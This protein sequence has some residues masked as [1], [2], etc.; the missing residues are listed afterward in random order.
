MT[1]DSQN[2]GSVRGL[3]PDTLIANALTA[4][5]P[6][7]TAGSENPKP[8]L[9]TSPENFSFSSQ[10]S[11]ET[12][13]AN[14]A[15]GAPDHCQ[16][17]WEPET[18]DG[19]GD[20]LCFAHD[21]NT[22]SSSLASQFSEFSPELDTADSTAF[23]DP[24]A[25]LSAGISPCTCITSLQECSAQL[26]SL[27]LSPVS[28]QTLTTM[29][30]AAHTLYQAIQCTVCRQCSSTDM[31]N[32]GLTR[33]VFRFLLHCWS[34]VARA[35]SHFLL[36]PAASTLY[37]TS[38]PMD[39]ALREK[40]W[41]KW[42]RHLFREGLIGSR[43][44]CLAEPLSPCMNLLSLVDALEFQQCYFDTVG[45][46]YL[47]SISSPSSSGSDNGFSSR[48]VSERRELSHLISKEVREFVAK[49]QFSNQETTG[50]RV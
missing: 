22:S 32:L 47:D 28:V 7:R 23:F 44:S 40:H 31:Q 2:Y 5:Q 17:Q 41:K 14:A 10:A 20:M 43:M 29:F 4:V 33:V 49:F 38:Q 18:F 36:N 3:L 26:A 35:G 19:T 1:L 37:I 25:D 13:L 16:T 39:P 15:M 12:I 11:P 48:I 21:L 6:A 27:F 8:V 30:A 34:N 45:H 9:P 24:A 50:I 46:V 42:L